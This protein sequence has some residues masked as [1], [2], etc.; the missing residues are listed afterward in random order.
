MQ[1]LNDDVSELKL[2]KPLQILSFIDHLCAPE[3]DHALTENMRS[4]N[5]FGASNSILSIKCC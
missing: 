5:S 2:L 4:Q 3:T 1:L